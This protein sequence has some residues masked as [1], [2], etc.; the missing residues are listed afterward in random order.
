MAAM[1]ELV[2][3]RGY[4]AVTIRDLTQLAGVSSRDFYQRYSGIEDC[5]LRTHALIASRLDRRVAESQEGETDEG[6]TDWR[7][8]LRVTVDAYLREL[9]DD[10]DAARLLLIDAYVAGPPALPQV[11]RAECALGMRMAECL[12]LSDERRDVP[13][14]L[15]QGIAGGLICVVRSRLARDGSASLAALTDDLANWAAAAFDAVRDM[16]SPLAAVPAWNPS[17]PPQRADLCPS[18][19][20]S[21]E[22][23]LIVTALTKL[24]AVEKYDEI[25]ARKVRQL[26]GASSR[27]FSDHFADVADCFQRAAE[28]YATKLAEPLEADEVEGNAGCSDPVA[29]LCEWVAGDPSFAALCFTD[30]FAPGPLAVGGV[31]CVVGGLEALLAGKAFRADEGSVAREASAAAVWATIREEIL[32]GRRSQLH[33]A[34]WQLW[35]L[36]GPCHGKDL[37]NHL[38]T[39]REMI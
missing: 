21:G 28:A 25:T 26:A 39:A 30:V 17:R 12:E 13:A 27:K 35:P 29:L 36:C 14:L 1:R 33:Q 37:D 4:R 18:P 24:A 6:E 34:A 8:C 9:R 19:F 3:Q 16:R 38:L 7:R 2:G 31:D 22:R 32:R 23:D 20:A 11:R 5:F 15:T 10:P